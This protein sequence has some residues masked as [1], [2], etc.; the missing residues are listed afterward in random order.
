M[1]YTISILCGFFFFPIY[2]KPNPIN[3]KPT[4]RKPWENDYPQDEYFTLHELER[5]MKSRKFSL[6]LDN[7][8]QEKGHNDLLQFSVHKV[9]KHKSHDTNFFS[10][11]SGIIHKLRS[12]RNSERK[13]GE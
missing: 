2:S 11:L 12:R 1:G 8:M 4:F 3:R 7:D 6:E 10:M 9:V 13:N 5:I